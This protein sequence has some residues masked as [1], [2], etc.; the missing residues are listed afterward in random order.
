MEIRSRKDVAEPIP[1]TRRP[2]AIMVDKE[3]VLAPGE[4]R[5]LEHTVIWDRMRTIE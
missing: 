4:A 3:I 1:C 2:A 5:G